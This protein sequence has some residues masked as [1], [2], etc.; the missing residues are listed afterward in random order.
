MIIRAYADDMIILTNCPEK[1]S[2]VLNLLEDF[3]KRRYLQLNK[4]KS[5]ILRMRTRNGIVRRKFSSM[6]GIP[7]VGQAK[8]LGVHYNEYLSVDFSIEG[9]KKKESFIFSKIYRILKCSGFRERYNLWQ[10]FVA[11]LYRMCIS[12]CGPYGSHRSKANFKIIQ[13]RARASLKKFCLTPR[14]APTG[15]FDMMI[16]FSDEYLNGRLME[17]DRLASGRTM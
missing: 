2:F 16:G 12:M 10:I 11:P 15:M 5:E 13:S 7:L 8:Y 3:C 17:W 1:L 4:A 6:M 9:F 14:T